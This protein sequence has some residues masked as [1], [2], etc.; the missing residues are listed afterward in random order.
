[1]LLELCG[2]F[3]ADGGVNCVSKKAAG[4]DGSDEIYENA[5][6]VAVRLLPPVWRLPGL[7]RSGA[8]RGVSRVSCYVHQLRCG[9]LQRSAEALSV[10]AVVEPQARPDHYHY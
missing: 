9:T 4:Q 8:A 2:L 6:A 10:P 7:A 5:P 1:M 3:L